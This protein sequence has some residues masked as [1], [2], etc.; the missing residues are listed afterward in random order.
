LTMFPEAEAEAEAVAAG[1]E[2]Y[3]GTDLDT[4]CRP[5]SCMEILRSSIGVVMTIWQRPALP[6]ASIS[7]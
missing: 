5:A 4:T 3:D 6:P 2:E 7:R 1:M